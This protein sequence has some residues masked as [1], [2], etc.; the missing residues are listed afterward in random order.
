MPPKSKS[1]IKTRKRVK[2]ADQYLPFIND[3]PVYEDPEEV[4]PK[5]EIL[6]TYADGVNDM[7][8]NVW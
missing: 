3:V 5:A 1:T 4:I 8:G 6:I 2:K 7:F